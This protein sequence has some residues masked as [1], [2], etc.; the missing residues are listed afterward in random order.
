MENPIELLYVTCRSKAE[1]A[2]IAAECHALSGVTPDQHGLAYLILRDDATQL[3]MADVCNA[4][5]V[6]KCI[7]ILAT[8]QDL[9]DMYACVESLGLNAEAFCVRVLK[10]AGSC[11]DKHRIMC[12]IGARISGEVDLSGPRTVFYLVIGAKRLW[13]GEVHQIISRDQEGST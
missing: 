11:A 5:Y 13:F 3:Y 8:S 6:K 9:N 7:R 2:L 4:A 12:E 1:R 10:V